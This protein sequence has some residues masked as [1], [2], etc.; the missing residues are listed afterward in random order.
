MQRS[1]LSQ[2]EGQAEELAGGGLVVGSG[3][4]HVQSQSLIEQQED[5]IDFQHNVG[6]D[7]DELVSS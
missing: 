3:H 2:R 5:F 4:P 7:G 6:S 1:K